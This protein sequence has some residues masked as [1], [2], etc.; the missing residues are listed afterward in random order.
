MRSPVHLRYFLAFFVALAIRSAVWAD[1]MA[2][3][4]EPSHK[5]RPLEIEAVIREVKARNPQLVAIKLRWEAA[6]EKLPQA[7]AWDDP[8]VGVD[9]ERSNRRLDSYDDAEWMISQ[10]IPVTGKLARRRDAANAEVLIAAAKIEEVELELEMR[11][12]TAY[13]RLADAEVQLQTNA[14]NQSLLR[15]ILEVTRAKYESGKLRQSDVLMAETELVK[16]EEARVDLLRSYSEAQSAI[17][18]L[19]NLPA[20]SPVGLARYPE[21][22]AQDVSLERLQSRALSTRPQLTAADGRIAAANARVALA[23]RERRPDPEFRIEARQFNGSALYDVHEYD[24]GVFISL[25]WFNRSKYQAAIREAKK[26][27]EA[28]QADREAIALQ[29]SALVRDVWQRIR[30]YQHHVELLRQR[31]LPLARQTVEASRSNYETDRATLP[32]VLL[33]QRTAEETEAML[34]DHLAEYFIAEAELIPLVGSSDFTAS[35][36]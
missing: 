27:A 33:A 28:N 14:Q 32:E 18:A 3:L 35:S 16:Q 31:L 17:N 5:G 36:K 22:T 20:Q 4:D 13:V 19:M 11:A 26:N 21:F 23:E 9:I 10:T 15:Q 24:T 30:T 7:S 2:H 1:T 12:R 8:R 29:T 25:P 34:N 6:K